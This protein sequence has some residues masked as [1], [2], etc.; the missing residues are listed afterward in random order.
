MEI[1]LNIVGCLLITLALLHIIFP[2][3]FNWTNELRSVSLVNRQMMYIHTF[4][5]ALALFLMGLLCLTSA[6]Q[7]IKTELG[8]KISFGF[9]IF[10]LAR[11][12]IQFFGYSPIL[13]K[14]KRLESA[15][16]IAF[17]I[18]WIYLSVVFFYV[19]YKPMG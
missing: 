18:L 8:N 15:I 16:H 9:G 5:I 3:Y 13:W 11:L 2:R 7:I 17:S 14:G 19:Y 12:I 10:W 1:N 4:F 6:Q